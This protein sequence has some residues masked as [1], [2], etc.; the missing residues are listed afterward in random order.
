MKTEKII[1]TKLIQAGRP[2]GQY[3]VLPDGNL[4]LKAIDLPEMFLPFDIA[5][6]PKSLTENGNNLCLILLEE[7]SHPPQTQVPARLLGGVRLN[8]V[9]PC[10][11]GVSVA[12]VR[13]ADLTHI[14]DL[15]DALREEIVRYLGRSFGGTQQLEWLDAEAAVKIARQAL[16]H[17]RQVKLTGERQASTKTAW[18]PVDREGRVVSYS[19]REHYTD[20]EYTYF[21]LPY[22]FQFYM[23]QHLAA[24]ERILFALSRPAM[25][26]RLQGSWLNRTKLQEGV[27]ILTNQRLVFLVELVPP[28]SSGVRYGFESRIGVLERLEDA[29]LITLDDDV[30]SLQTT[31]RA[32]AGVERLEWEFPLSCRSALQ[33]LLKLLL[34]FVADSHGSSA[35]RR[36]TLPTAP[37]KLSPLRDPATN[38][39]K[40]N[41]RISAL[42]SAG[43]PDWLDADEIFLSWALLPAWFDKRGIAHILLLTNRRIRLIPEPSSHVSV[44]ID[45]SYSQISS[46]EYVSSI[47]TSHIGLS[48]VNSGRTQSLKINFPYPAEHAFHSCFET[49]RRCLAVVPEV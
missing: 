25:R 32:A 44:E 36:T 35:L 2:V 42:F 30:I 1:E 43:L 18:L 16:A 6:L 15:P 40:A 14:E 26:S 37:E 3:Q 9:E 10:L 19:E 47:L 41:E 29:T 8:G 28:D 23:D 12:D 24:D 33:E 46:L 38:D 27:L 4:V 20:A 17:A 5:V 48:V 31:W 49:L 34:K 21:L 11:L 7:I 39:P 22:R 13:Y 45:I